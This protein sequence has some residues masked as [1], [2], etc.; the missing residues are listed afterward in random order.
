MRLELGLSAR[1]R[2]TLVVGT[3]SIGSMF[4]LSRGLPALREWERGQV[5]S[6]AAAVEQE[7]EA[8]LGLRQLPSM[9]D[10]LRARASRMAAID[11]TLLRNVSP[12]AAAADLAAMLEGFASDAPMKIT[13]M[14]LNADTSTSSPLTVVSV[15][16]IGTTDVAGLASFIGAVE[17][18]PTP[19]SVSEMAVTQPEPSAPEE[20]PE[21]LRVDV[22]VKG[23]A[24]ITPEKH[25]T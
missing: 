12:P 25:S 24:R 1:D 8:R 10:S 21:A 23:L 11:S 6:A 9:R 15:R 19:L 17:G 16:V 18:G 22:V 14:Q 5:S 3:V 20:K 4:G 7:T 13:T 2:R